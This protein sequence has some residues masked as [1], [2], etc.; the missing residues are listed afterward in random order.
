VILFAD[1]NVSFPSFSNICTSIEDSVPESDIRNMIDEDR[2]LHYVAMTRAKDCLAIFGNFSNLGVY[3]MESLGIMDFGKESNA[4][5]IAMAQHGLS[6]RLVD[7]TKEF[8]EKNPEYLLEIDIKDL[9]TKVEQKYNEKKLQTKAENNLDE[10]SENPKSEVTSGFNINSI[11][12][13]TPVATGITE[14]CPF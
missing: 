2:R 14:D 5:I 13:Y 3:T 11:Q 10:T 6:K 7:N 12:T 1:D 4:N 8:I 9:N